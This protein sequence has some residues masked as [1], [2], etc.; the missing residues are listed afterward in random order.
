MYDYIIV[1]AGISGLYTAYKLCKKYPTSKIC[2]LE[3][4]QYVGGRLH[5]IKYDG[6]I[7]NGGGARFNTDQKRII[8]LIKEVGL[9]NKITPITGDTTYKPIYKY[10]SKDYTILSNIFP[11][12]NDFILFMKKYIKDK[13]IKRDILINTTILEF[14]EEYFSKEYPHIKQYLINIYPYYSEL[15][16][17][18][19]VE[20]INLFSNEFSS[21]TKYFVLNGGLAQITDMIYN[22]LKVLHKNK[23][24]NVDIYKET[25]VLEITKHNCNDDG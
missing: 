10:N 1:G 5:T 3:A 6:V 11:T 4:T 12:I 17:L 8:S 18:N 23:K 2:I 14:A 21:K 24:C 15:A 22:K 25:S 13:N 9:W 7:M 16:I 19:A 20:G